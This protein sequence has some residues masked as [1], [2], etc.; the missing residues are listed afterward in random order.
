M[1]TKLG[2]ICQEMTRIEDF[3]TIKSELLVTFLF[4]SLYSSIWC[5]TS[6]KKESSYGHSGVVDNITICY[7]QR[8]RHF[9]CLKLST[10]LSDK[11]LVEG[12]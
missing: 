6:F 5:F 7:Q 8:A 9:S 1:I 10:A 11:P 4:V 12:W 2:K 3:V